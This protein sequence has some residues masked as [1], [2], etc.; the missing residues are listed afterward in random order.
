MG[1]MGMGGSGGGMRGPPMGMGRGGQGG[2]MRGPPQGMMR[3][4]YMSL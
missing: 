4:N 3:G 1:G 2:Q